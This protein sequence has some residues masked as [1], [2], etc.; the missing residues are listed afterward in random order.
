M[1][2]VVPENASQGRPQIVASIKWGSAV[3]FM[4][5]RRVRVEYQTVVVP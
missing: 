5:K 4:H 3:K 1:F 2:D